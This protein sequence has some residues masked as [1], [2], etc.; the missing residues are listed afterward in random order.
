M[1]S[2]VQSLCALLCHNCTVDVSCKGA[3][4]EDDAALVTLLQL[5]H[6]FPPMSGGGNSRLKKKK[7][8]PEQA[9]RLL[10]Q[11]ENVSF[12]FTPLFIWY[13]PA[14][15]CII[16]GEKNYDCNK[17]LLTSPIIC[18]MRA[19]QTNA[20]ICSFKRVQVYCILYHD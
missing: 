19:T 4:D 8:S 6:L 11:E 1:L 13:R 9:L 17:R 14:F 15:Y 10:I 7:I 16:A 5:L 20:R 2:L 18:R 12:I 3:N